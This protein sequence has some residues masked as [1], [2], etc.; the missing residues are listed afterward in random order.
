MMLRNYLLAQ[1]LTSEGAG[2]APKTATLFLVQQHHSV[3]PRQPQAEVGGLPADCTCTNAPFLLIDPLGSHRI[4]RYYYSTGRLPKGPLFWETPEAASGDKAYE[5]V[6]LAGMD[7]QNTQEG[8]TVTLHGFLVVDPV[9]NL[10][11]DK[12]N[13]AIDVAAYNPVTKADPKTISMLYASET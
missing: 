9:D 1:N 3:P 11:T 2:A 4:S 5:C 7:L 8:V 12:K 10:Y 13:L 6:C